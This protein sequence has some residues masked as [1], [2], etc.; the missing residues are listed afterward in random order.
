MAD[1]VDENKNDQSVLAEQLHSVGILPTE[2]YDRSPDGDTFLFALITVYLME[3]KGY[4]IDSL[5]KFTT[6]HFVN[7]DD[8]CVGDGGSR[9]F[10]GYE[11]W[12]LSRLEYDLM[13]LYFL[14]VRFNWVTSS[15]TSIFVS[16]PCGAYVSRSNFFFIDNLGLPTIDSHLDLKTILLSLE[17]GTVSYHSV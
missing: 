16:S 9:L 6:Y 13:R 3:V 5:K 17:N 14:R 15:D 11:D 8:T 1:S 12:R 10:E 2:T 4:S 7:L